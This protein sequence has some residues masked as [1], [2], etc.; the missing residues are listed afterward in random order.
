MFKVLRK[1]HF[2]GKDEMVINY[3][4]IKNISCFQGN[5]GYISISVDGGIKPYSYLWLPTLDTTD[6]IVNLFAVPHVIRVV[7]SVSCTQIDTIDLY[8]ITSPIQTQSSIVSKV[9]C[10]QGSN[11]QLTTQSFGGMPSYNYIWTDI[12]SDTVSTSVIASDLIAGTYFL[13]VS[14]SFNCGPA[15]DTIILT[16]YPEIEIDVINIVDNICFGDRL[17]EFTFF[18]SGGNPNYTINISDENNNIASTLSTS[19]FDLPSSLYTVWVED[20]NS[21]ISDTLFG[22]KLAEPGRIQIHNNITNLS[23]YQYQDGWMNIELKNTPI[24]IIML[25]ILIYRFQNQINQ[26]VSFNVL[27]LDADDYLVEVSDFNGCFVDSVFI[28]TQPDQIMADFT[29]VSDF[30]RESF[31]F[32][33]QNT[34]L[35]GDLYYWDFDNDSNKISTYFQEIKTTFLNQGEYNVMMVAHDTLLGYQ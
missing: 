19:I 15:T 3:F 21:C 25:L 31:M 24:Q 20:D 32:E 8:E 33:A 13:F 2:I 22:V 14:D 27:N 35:G 29:T 18:I 23:C 7:D 5:D 16:Q 10:F 26:L 9:S 6:L 28:V 4:S 1:Y 17:G 30:G 11:G 12:N 34:S